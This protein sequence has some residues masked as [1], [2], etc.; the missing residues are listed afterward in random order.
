MKHVEDPESDLPAALIQAKEWFGGCYPAEG[1]RGHFTL[2]DYQGHWAL[3]RFL[4]AKTVPFALSNA[5]VAITD[6]AVR[7]FFDPSKMLDDP[8]PLHREIGAE[9]IKRRLE[10]YQSFID[11]ETR[12]PWNQQNFEVLPPLTELPPEQQRRLV[13]WWERLHFDFLDMHP[14]WRWTPQMGFWKTGERI[15]PL[16]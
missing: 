12:R 8:A 10:A 2:K 14:D 7:W 11:K 15:F 16:V 3:E 9:E 13:G 5:M 4:A 6:D 1:G